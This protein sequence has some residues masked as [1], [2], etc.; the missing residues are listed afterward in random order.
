[1]SIGNST[2]NATTY[3]DIQAIMISPEGRRIDLSNVTMIEK[4]KP[5]YE[6]ISTMR[7]DGTNLHA[8]LPKCWKGSFEVARKDAEL[9][10]MFKTIAKDW[11]ARGVYRLG[12]ITFFITEADGSVTKE[13][14]GGVSFTFDDA[15]TF[16][17]KEV[18]QKV[19]FTAQSQ[20]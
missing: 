17:N 11:K 5:E 19:S 18:T 2:F 15:G 8:D 3:R 12:S 1:M 6:T 9:E 10:E 7:L 20:D 16:S 14:Y 13:I 4:P